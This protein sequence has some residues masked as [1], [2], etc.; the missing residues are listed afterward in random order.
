M[1]F[2]GTR[3]AFAG[4]Q[5]VNS[6]SWALTYPG[7]GDILDGGSNAIEAGD[8]ILINVGRD[9]T[10]GTGS[11]SGFTLLFDQASSANRGQTFAKVADGTESG[12]FSYTSGASEQGAWRIA[13]IKDW[14][15]TIATG[16]AVSASAT[17]TSANPNPA[18]L[19][20]SWGA[21]DTYWRTVCAFDDGRRSITA[22]PSS[23]DNFN[24]FQNSDASGGSGGA[25]MGSA[26]LDKNAASVDPGTFTLSASV[27]WVAWLIAIRPAP[28]S[29]VYRGNQAWS[30]RY[31]GARS[32]ASLYRGAKTLHP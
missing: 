31:R 12:T 6:T 13:V 30:N 23:P 17:G 18:S 4:T 24:L 28:P 27:G 22:Y 10:T 11:I 2:P 32:D 20:P 25:G 9:G 29:Y 16:V 8:L 15:G 3:S 26:G 21:A 19:T 5:N 7:A 14:W 1:T